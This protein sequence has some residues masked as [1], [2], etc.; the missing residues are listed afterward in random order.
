MVEYRTSRV[1]STASNCKVLLVFTS[2]LIESP[3]GV[4]TASALSVFT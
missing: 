1:V 2:A 3:L 4:F